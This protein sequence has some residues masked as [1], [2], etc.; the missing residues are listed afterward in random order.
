MSFRDSSPSS[1]W[2]FHV[3][4]NAL[5]NTSAHEQARTCLLSA[6]LDNDLCA[7]DSRYGGFQIFVSA[8]EHTEFHAKCR[9]IFLQLLLLTKVTNV[10]RKLRD[11]KL[12]ANTPVSTPNFDSQE[13]GVQVRARAFHRRVSRSQNDP[14]RTMTLSQN[15][16]K[17]APFRTNEK[18]RRRSIFFVPCNPALEGSSPLEGGNVIIVWH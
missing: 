1:R 10:C 12:F 3:S 7:H 14:F 15:C 17:N 18:V 16:K 13:H 4:S 11:A 8:V 6:V 2:N 5:T 9:L